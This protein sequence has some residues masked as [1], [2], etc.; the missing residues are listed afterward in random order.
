MF[1]GM[2]PSAGTRRPDEAPAPYGGYEAKD[3]AEDSALDPP[4]PEWWALL[5]INAG[6]VLVGLVGIGSVTSTVLGAPWWALALTALV[7]AVAAVTIELHRIRRQLRPPSDAE[8]SRGPA[9]T[10][11][12][13]GRERL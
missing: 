5:M 1:P 12:T 10:V 13:H 3:R 7:L 8:I 9:P 4:E 6:G 2:L 11:P